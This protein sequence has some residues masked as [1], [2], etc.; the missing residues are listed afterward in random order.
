MDALLHQSNERTN[1]EE[2]FDGTTQWYRLL[3]QWGSVMFTDPVMGGLETAE[4]FIWN[5]DK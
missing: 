4:N 2:V 1:H 5:E 3:C